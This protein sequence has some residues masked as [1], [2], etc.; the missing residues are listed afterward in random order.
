MIEVKLL[1][2]LHRTS[3]CSCIFMH[4]L[5]SF[6]PRFFFENIKPLLQD[7]T[8]YCCFM[9]VLVAQSETKHQVMPATFCTSR[10]QCIASTCIMSLK[11]LGVL[12]LRLSLV[13]QVLVSN[14]FYCYPDSWGKWSNLTN[15]SWDG[16]VQPPA[17]FVLKVIY[18][19]S[20][21]ATWITFH[22]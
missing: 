18:F 5:V 16:L 22:Y 19:S 15:I 21:L 12:V 1:V 4:F 9:Y 6:F 14:I 8:L 7:D 11:S 3:W 17:S 2:C 20:D 10:W 13:Y